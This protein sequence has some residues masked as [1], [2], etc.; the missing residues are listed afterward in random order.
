MK[1]GLGFESGPPLLPTSTSRIWHSSTILV[2]FLSLLTLRA[3]PNATGGRIWFSFKTVFLLF[4]LLYAKSQIC[5]KMLREDKGIWLL[6][7]SIV[8]EYDSH[9]T[10]VCEH[11][12][13]Y[14]FV[15]VPR[16]KVSVQLSISVNDVLVMQVF[17]TGT[18]WP[19]CSSWQRIHRFHCR[20]GLTWS[21]RWKEGTKIFNCSW[22]SSGQGAIQSLAC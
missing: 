12:F 18:N 21:N 14:Y 10:L 5:Y 11:T 20:Q 15:L 22:L 16:R 6:K 4:N 8:P 13:F 3:G 1:A 2:S 7:P 9:F 17:P 19:R